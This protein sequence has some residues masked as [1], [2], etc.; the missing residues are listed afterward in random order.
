MNLKLVGSLAIG[1]VVA[2]AVFGA[3]AVRDATASRTAVLAVAAFLGTACGVAAIVAL[4]RRRLRWSGVF[5]VLSAISP[6][7]FAWVVNVAAL[8][9][10]GYLVASVRKV[11]T[12]AQS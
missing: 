5:L 11:R 7:T 8:I 6:T 9:L 12:P 10:G 2:E 4:K 1:C 3:L